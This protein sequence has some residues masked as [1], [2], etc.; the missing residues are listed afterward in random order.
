[1]T[2]PILVHTSYF[3]FFKLQFQLGKLVKGEK[4][5]RVSKIWDI[6]RDTERKKNRITVAQ[7]IDKFKC[8]QIIIL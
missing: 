8:K 6:K 5:Y 7:D 3:L 2:T 4:I 1:M